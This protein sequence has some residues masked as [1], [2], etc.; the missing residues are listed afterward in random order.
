MSD[1]VERAENLWR[2]S[3]LAS[4]EDTYYGDARYALRAAQR[5]DWDRGL[6]ELN[7]LHL[8]TSA[9]PSR[10]R[11]LAGTH[12]AALS[13]YNGAHDGNT[14][15]AFGATRRFLWEARLSGGWQ[16]ELLALELFGDLLTRAGHL[17]EAVQ[18]YLGAGNSKKAVQVALNLVTMV[19]D[20]IDREEPHHA[21]QAA[22]ALRSARAALE[23]T[24]GLQD[25]IDTEWTWADYPMPWLARDE[26]REVSQEAQRIHDG[27]AAGR[28]V[29]HR[30][31]SIAASRRPTAVRKR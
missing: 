21:Q 26:I 23:I 30:S 10:K 17:E 2:Q 28:L 16:E 22:T 15:E 20:R 14:A 25:D 4:S 13:A 29:I 6:L 5:S 9:L 18:T 19:L 11:L 3:V 7:G 27:I 1:V 24:P 12:D 8:I 31:H